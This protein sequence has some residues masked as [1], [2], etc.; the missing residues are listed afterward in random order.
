MLQSIL[1]LCP[2]DNVILDV[3]EDNKIAINLYLKYGF[4]FT[5]KHGEGLVEMVKVKSS[6]NKED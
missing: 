5:G 1:E 3:Y 2:S 4:V 6:V